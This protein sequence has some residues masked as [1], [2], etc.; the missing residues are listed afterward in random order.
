MRVLLFTVLCVFAALPALAN[1]V[2]DDVLMSDEAFDDAEELHARLEEISK[3]L[4]EDNRKHL[5]A[6]YYAHNVIGS[7]T[8]VSNDVRA[9]VTS[10]TENNP[11]LDV[12]L[13][14]RHKDWSEAV[15]GAL[16]EADGQVENMIIAQDYAKTG[17]IRRFLKRADKTREKMANALNKVPVTTEEACEH[18][19]DTLES[20]QGKLIKSLGDMQVSIQKAISSS[21]ADE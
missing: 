5:M 13:Q 15:Q 4:S 7:V 17:V 6:I 21:G 16:N 20:T 18:L 14:G 8:T 3:D 19:Y 9:A 2:A 1:D 12:D 11:D 10:C